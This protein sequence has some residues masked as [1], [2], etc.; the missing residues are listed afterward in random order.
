MVR[1][2]SIRRKMAGRVK[3]WT[4][5]SSKL[6]KMAKG[7]PNKTQTLARA[8]RK[9]Q[10]QV[11]KDHQILHYG[12]NFSTG[13]TADYTAIKL[14]N[15]VNWNDIFGQQG[16][17]DDVD[18]TIYHQNMLIDM[19]LTLENTVNEPDTTQFSIFIVSLK[20]AIGN[21]YNNVTGDI[22]LQP[23]YHYYINGGL[24]ILNKQVM[25]IHYAHR[26]VLSNHGQALSISSAQTQA[27][28]DWRKY[29]SM[30]MPNKKI[31]SPYQ[32]WKTINCPP[33]PSDNYYL[34]IFNDNSAIDLQ[35]PKIQ[36]STVHTMRSV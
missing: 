15:F 2:Q 36:V 27:G 8:V 28:T 3:A 33:D 7:K 10:K 5:S 34:L 11:N 29:I 16:G 6:N 20:D 23:N 24:V 9:L 30:K 12:Q 14:C 25:K 21:S 1:F 32:D 35:N 4:S 13:V 22:T 18:N 31:H 17:N 26:C 19:Y